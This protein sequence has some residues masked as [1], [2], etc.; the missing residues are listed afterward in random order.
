LPKH[1]VATA[2]LVA[3]RVY[4]RLRMHKLTRSVDFWNH[5]VF[6]DKAATSC[7]GPKRPKVPVQSHPGVPIKGHKRQ[8]MAGYPVA[9]IGR[10]QKA[11][12]RCKEVE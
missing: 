5:G 11:V 3:R 4:I 7:G 2:D 10:E 1:L 12:S 9:V 8:K 6:P